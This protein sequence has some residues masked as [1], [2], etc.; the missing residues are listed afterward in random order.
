V[1]RV[2]HDGN[3]GIPND[4]GEILDRLTLLTETEIFAQ[5]HLVETRYAQQCVDGVGVIR[6]IG[7]LAGL[8]ISAIANHQRHALF[9]MRNGRPGY[10]NTK[11]N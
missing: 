8:L 4:I 10:D 6:R 3:V 5:H 7:Q 1:A 9:S 2:V 11:K